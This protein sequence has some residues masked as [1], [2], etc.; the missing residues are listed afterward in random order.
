MSQDQIA[1][2]CKRQPDDG[3][4]EGVTRV[5]TQ[6][7]AGRVGTAGQAFRRGQP[8]SAENQSGANGR[9]EG[10]GPCGS[11]LSRRAA[12]AKAQDRT[13]LQEGEKDIIK[14]KK[15]SVAAAAPG[16]DGGVYGYVGL[17]K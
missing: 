4:R 7:Y 17:E 8:Q 9:G 10:A 16:E 15:S 2:V 1:A 14:K 6:V 13:E 3:L 5:H 12:G 11:L